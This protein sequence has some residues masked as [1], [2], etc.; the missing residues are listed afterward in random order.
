M[1]NPTTLAKVKVA[2]SSTI[3]VLLLLNSLKN[4][5]LEIEDVLL[6]AVEVE[7]V[8]VIPSLKDANT[9]IP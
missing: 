7:A 9:S 5:V 3:S 1:L 6:M 2:H 4:T 8:I